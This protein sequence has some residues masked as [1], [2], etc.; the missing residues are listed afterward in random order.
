MSGPRVA[1]LGLIATVA[2]SVGTAAP[3]L[4][5][6]IA[7]LAYKLLHQRQFWWEPGYARTVSHGTPR[8]LEPLY[9]RLSI[10][11]ISGHRA[12]PN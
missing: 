6:S 9:H 10:D 8:P 12:T 4:A 3:A 5:S 2:I 11:E 7:A 1:F